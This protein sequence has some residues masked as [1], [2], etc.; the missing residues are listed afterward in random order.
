M[1]FYE[2]DLYH[3]SLAPAIIALHS[4]SS[5]AKIYVSSYRC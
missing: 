3:E 4:L 2:G 5:V 1:F